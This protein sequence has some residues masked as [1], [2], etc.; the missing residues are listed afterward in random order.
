MVLEVGGKRLLIDCGTDCRHLLAAKYGDEVYANPPSR[1]VDAIYISHIHADHC[2]G[3]EWFAFTNYFMKGKRVPLI[4]AESLIEEL[5]D[6]SLSGGLSQ[7]TEKSVGLDEYFDVVAIKSDFPEWRF[8]GV[9]PKFCIYPCTH[10]PGGKISYALLAE[11]GEKGVLISTDCAFDEAWQKLLVELGSSDRVVNIFH[12]C[13][14]GP[15]PNPVHTHYT[16]LEKLP[17]EIKK[18]MWLY[19]YRPS[20]F[21]KGDFA[22]FVEKGEEFRI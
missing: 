4:I 12:D 15:A 17:V 7:L 2:G 9:D 8:T 14:T 16:A 10:V 5:W 19:H 3:L 1:F 21:L 20:S 13:D 6:R 22:G 18:K 11:E